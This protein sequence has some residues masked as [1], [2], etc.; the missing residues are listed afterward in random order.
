MENI[1]FGLKFGNSL[2]VMVVG[3]FVVFIVLAV[4]ILIC[5]VMGKIFASAVGGKK[6]EKKAEP[7][8][9]PAPA[10]APVPAPAA[11][12]VQAEDEDEI[13]AVIAAVVAAMGPAK[14][15]FIVRRVRRVGSKWGSAAR[16]EILSS[17]NF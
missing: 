11:P 1:S 10:P 7:K 4:L 12:A 6:T 15:D 8:Q 16:E 14:K 3:V 2:L 5:S 9:A 17:R 13:A